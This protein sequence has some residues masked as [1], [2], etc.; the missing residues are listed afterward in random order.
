MR[1]F[2]WLLV[3]CSVRFSS[4]AHLFRRLAAFSLADYHVFIQEISQ[5]LL[6]AVP[7][8]VMSSVLTAVFSMT[9]MYD[10]FGWAEGL[11]FG[12]MLSATDP[13][14]VVRR[15]AFF[16]RARQSNRPD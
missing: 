16:L 14:A 10:D 5:M 7:G 2:V 4:C 1:R 6:L 8:V 13:V 12:A 15:G 11:T 3:S 9:A